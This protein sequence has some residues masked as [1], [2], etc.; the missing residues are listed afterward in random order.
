MN[1]VGITNKKSEN[2][3]IKSVFLCDGNEGLGAY[4]KI[5]H[6]LGAQLGTRAKPG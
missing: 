1:F 5:E 3:Y 2:W 4:Y 6:R